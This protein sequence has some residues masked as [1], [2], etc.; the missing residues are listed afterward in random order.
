[1]TRVCL[2]TANLG[3]FDP[4]VPPV[5]QT[6]PADVELTYVPITDREFPPRSKT[7]T[8]RLQA[9]IPKCF[10][11]EMVPG[12]DAYVWLDASFTLQRPDAIAWIWGHLQTADVVTFLHPARQTVAEEAD[13]L[14]L[15]VSEGNRYIV[16]RYAGELVDEQM[17]AL[18]GANYPDTVLYGTMLVAYWDRPHV[19]AMLRDWWF[20]ISRYHAVDQL[21]FPFV[22]WQHE[23][24]VA[25]LG[26]RPY[27]NPYVRF[28][29]QHHR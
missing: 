27:K 19:R 21:A 24:S 5:P 15:G 8:P 3:N 26:H 29:R 25:T 20:H 14:R 28:V 7:M 9:R 13:F 11:W 4:I 17:W 10:G 22:L 2:L 18:A 6:L 23:C 12:H 1:M 16:P